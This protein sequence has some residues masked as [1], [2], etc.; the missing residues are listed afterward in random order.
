M[1]DSGEIMRS[2]LKP[3]GEAYTARG[4]DTSRD[5]I[6]TMTVEPASEEE[7]AGTIKVM[8]GEDWELWIK[9]LK[10]AGVLAEG[11]KTVAYSYIGTEITW[12]IYW[13]G[14]I[15][16]AKEDLDRAATALRAEL[17]DINGSANVAILK[18]VVTQA[19][20]A[21]PVLPLYISIV[22]KVMKEQGVHEGCIEQVER[23]LRTQ[24]YRDDGK[25]MDVDD[26]ERLRLDDKELTEEV[27]ST[28][29]AVWE[30][31]T[32]ETLFSES[33]YQG[34]KDEFLRL[35]GFGFDGVD[36][37]ADVDPVVNFEVIDL[38]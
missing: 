33:D 5:I 25:A 20:S 1:P 6:T 14:S 16:K 15:G 21:I 37:E 17:A 29:T 12:P 22:F 18:S 35:F 31:I 9:A 2:T 34:Y 36:Y 32:Q 3:I 7:V 24:L 10:D 23:M 4:V 26:A 19:S 38:T 11:A 8:G 28:S 13:H 30:G 27:Q